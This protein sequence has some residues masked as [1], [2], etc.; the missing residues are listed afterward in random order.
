VGDGSTLKMALAVLAMVA[1]VAMCVHKQE[2][3]TRL[4]GTPVVGAP[5]QDD[6]ARRAAFERDGYQIAPFARF[7]VRARLLS[8]ERY[9]IGRE[10]DLSPIDFA[11]GWDAMSHDSVLDRLK[12]SQGNRFYYYRWENEPPL[13]VS[14]IVRSSANMHLIPAGADVRQQLEGVR[15]GAV[16]TL[17]GWLVDVAA[18][19]GWRWA[20]S[21]TREDSGGGACELMWVDEVHVDG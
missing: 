3:T 18:P 8:A 6:G 15:P 21:R 4:P 16:V 19:D 7:T 9:R 5:R 13:P 10:A 2:S 11:L 14:E 17:H 20:S 12:I 1:S